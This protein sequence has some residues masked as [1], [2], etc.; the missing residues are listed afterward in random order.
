MKSARA[1]QAAG[2]IPTIDSG[3]FTL[4]SN[5]VKTDHVVAMVG[6]GRDTDARIAGPPE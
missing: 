6:S 1:A 4:C 5:L 3:M 2:T